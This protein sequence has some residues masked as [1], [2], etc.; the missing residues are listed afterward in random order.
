MFQ[1]HWEPSILNEPIYQ[2]SDGQVDTSRTYCSRLRELGFRAGDSQP[3]TNHDFRAEGV[4][5]I[6]KPEFYFLSS[7]ILY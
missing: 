5:L 2:R 4:Y 1:L 3:P 7:L 6:G